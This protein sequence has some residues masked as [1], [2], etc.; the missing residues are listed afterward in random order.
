MEEKYS[1]TVQ[2]YSDG[3]ALNNPGP[4]G[5]GTIVKYLDEKTTNVTKTEEFAE[6]FPATTNNRM[7][8]LGA[9][10]GLESLT[11]PSNVTITSDSSYL[12]NGIKKDWLANWKQNNWKTS[13]G[14]PVKNIDLWKRIDSL[15]ALHNVEFKWVKGHAGHP[16]NERCDY[17]AR[18]FASG[19]K[20]KKQENG[21]YSN[22]E[23][24]SDVSEKE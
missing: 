3:S 23:E 22:E 21:I 9:I 12:V 18:T 16:E 6:G 8:M 15:L 14:K 11:S 20:L 7:E 19:K 17:L 13:T 2:L 5:Y 10:V 24:E 4:G 1:Q